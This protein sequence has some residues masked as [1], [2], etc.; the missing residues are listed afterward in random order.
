MSMR[1]FVKVCK[2][3]NTISQRNIM[4]KYKKTEEDK[5][6]IKLKKYMIYNLKS[7]LHAT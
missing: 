5:E 7:V 2:T 3:L 4:K 6:N 1:F